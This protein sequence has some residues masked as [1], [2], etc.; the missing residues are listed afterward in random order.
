MSDTV[1][2][3]VDDGIGTITMDD[4]KANVMTVPMI[5]SL[6]GA[7][8]QAA[9]D[10]VVTV[11][12]GRD[13]IFSAGYDMSSFTQPIEQIAVMM[14]AGGRLIER[15][16]AHPRPVIAACNGHAIAQGA[17]TLLACDVRIGADVDAKIGLNE[18]AIGLTIPHYGIEVAR[19]QLTSTWF[20]HAT[21]TGTLY[22]VAEATT[23]GF[24]HHVVDPDT[25]ADH[26]AREAD[27][28]TAIDTTAHAGTKS[29]VRAAVLTAIDHGITEEFSTAAVAA[30]TE[31]SG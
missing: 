7:F 17:F 2:Y 25:L 8:Q 12:T 19:H 22:T 31:R 9:G 30:F 14:R 20:D 26:A 28:L 18:V 11:L 3:D 13:G 4:G 5:E 29:R 15:I 16:L 24:L 23:A 1:T 6:A 21:L 27:R 10:G